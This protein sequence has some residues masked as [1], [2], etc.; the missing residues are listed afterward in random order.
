MGIE[1]EYG[2]SVPGHPHVNSMLTSSQIVNAYANSVVGGTAEG[3]VG[4]RRGDAAA[5]RAR[6]RPDPRRGRPQPAHRRGPRSGQ[7]HPHQRRPALRRPRPPGVLQPR[8]HQP[9][10]RAW[11]GTRPASASWHGP[12]SS[13]AACRARQPVNLYKNNTDNKGASY[14]TPRELPHAPDHPVR[15]RRP[16]PHAVLRLAAGGDRRRPGRARAGGPHP[17]LPALA[18]R[19]LLRG[20]GGPRDHAEAADHQHPRRAARRSGEVPPAARDRRRR[21]PR[22]DL[23]LPQARHHLA[24]AGHARGRRARPRPGDA[25]RR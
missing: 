25:R 22:R 8:G 18:A 23:D 11:C 14:G 12:S 24:G 21:Q 10:R 3:P 9:A 17:R 20:R 2:I 7:R 16:P 19:G 6:L 4:L 15:R 1:T 13:C 5:R